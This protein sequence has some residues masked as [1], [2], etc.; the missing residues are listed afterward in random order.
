MA[1]RRHPEHTGPEQGEREVNRITFH[2][3]LVPGLHSDRQTVSGNGHRHH[4]PLDR[5][6]HAGEPHSESP[7]ALKSMAHLNLSEATP[8]PWMVPF[9]ETH[10]CE[11][12]D[13]SSEVLKS[14]NQPSPRFFESAGHAWTR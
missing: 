13:P 10:I 12:C 7:E 3:V 11:R 5:E 4:H 14:T 6:P 2:Q 8:M 9:E 1:C